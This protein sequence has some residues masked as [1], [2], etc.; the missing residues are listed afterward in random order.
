MNETDELKKENKGRFIVTSNA[1]I[2][3][4]ERILITK[5]NLV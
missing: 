4:Q 1:F 3:K 2:F 5:S